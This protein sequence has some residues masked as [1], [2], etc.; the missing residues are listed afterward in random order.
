M[1]ILRN[2]LRRMFAKKSSWVYLLLIPIALNI[3]IVVLSSQQAKW[4]IGVHDADGTALTRSFVDTFAADSEI[5]D[6]PDPAG[7]QNALLDAE[8]DLLIVFP[9][10]HTESV[11]D[12]L[13]PAAEVHVRGDNNQTDS[14]RARIGTFLSGVNA[15]GQA[16]AGDHAL[17]DAGLQDYLERKYDAEYTNFAQGSAEEASRAIATLGYLAFGLMMMMGSAAGLLLEDRQR[18]IY[19]RVRLTPLKQ[20]SYFFQYFASMGVI[21]ATQLVAVMSV[22]P[23]MTGVTYGSTVAQ[24]AGVAAATLCFALFCVAKS[25]MVYRFAPTAVA[26]MTINSLIDVPMLMIGGALWPREIMPEPL[27][28][29]GEYLPTH[30][31]LDAGE[32]AVN[33]AGVRALATPLALL[34]GVSVVLVLGFSI[35]TRRVR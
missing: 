29:I 2:N 11:V 17:F 25:V 21:A 14:L 28:R 6:V 27:Q 34:V 23:V 16:A 35:R 8:Y 26:A 24:W 20:R 13:A 5:V 1:T 4:V 12:G 18:G 32:L 30:W 7:W 15:V 33:G 9:E 3:G 10:G 31:Y 22:L 19:E